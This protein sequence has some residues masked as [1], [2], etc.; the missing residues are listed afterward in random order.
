MAAKGLAAAMATSGVLHAASDVIAQLLVPPVKPLSPPTAGTDAV[1][2]GKGRWAVDATRV[3]KFALVGTILHGPFFYGHFRLMERVVGPGRTLGAVVA[4]ALIG[5][6]VSF[7]V[8]LLGFFPLRGA[9]DGASAQEIRATIADKLPRTVV[10]GA[11]VW[12][13]ANLLNFALVPLPY[14]LV[15]VNCIGLGWQTYL[16]HI[17]AST[18]AS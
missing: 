15:Y 2:E 1:A 3:A 9:L 17:A 12:V 16:S 14:R 11:A 10:A 4:K 8:Y 6:F 7:P 18:P 13:P 5:Q